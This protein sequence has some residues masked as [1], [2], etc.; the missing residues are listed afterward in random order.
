MADPAQ[1][2]RERTIGFFEIVV[3]NDGDYQRV[4]Q[5][6]WEQTLAALA[7]TPIE[8]RTLEAESTFVGTTTTYDEEDHL[9]LHRVKEGGEWLSVVNWKT[10]HLQELEARAGE[11]ILDTSVMCF[12]SFGNV[13]AIMQGSQAAPSH[14]SLQT[15]LNGLHF[16]SSRL[17]VRPLL[18]RA[19]VERLRTA[20][21]ASRAEIRIGRS[22]IAALRDH[23]GRLAQFLRLAS[24]EYGDID[25]TMIIS[26][27]RGRARDEDR[28]KLLDDLRDISDV[29]PEAAERAQ[30]SLV[31]AEDA[32][33][34]YRRLI[35]LVEHHITA[36][37]RVSAVDAEGH[38]IR[39]SS[40]VAVMLG[41]AAEH[42][43]ELRLASEV[44]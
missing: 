38:S 12:L 4:Q 5:L 39:I 18:S 19:E 9:L 26:I 34:E 1:T 42:D 41:A 36:K 33:P 15:W 29:V 37:R 35:E 24:D 30:A 16:F 22:K 31:Y 8:K 10:G 17:V 2:M 13:V 25:V 21:G 28:R 27:P 43:A 20:Q 11:G 44:I 23:R 32:G 3:D 6:P 40:A 14:K 7:G